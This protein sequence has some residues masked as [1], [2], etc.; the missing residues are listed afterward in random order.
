M[1][2]FR[3]DDD[4]LQAFASKLGRLGVELADLEAP[5]AEA[6]RI[7]L[8]AMRPPRLTG[9][10][11]ASTR[12]DVTAQGVTFAS[13]ARY[14]TFVHWGAPRRN[15]KARPFIT[16]AVDQAATD[17]AAVYAEHATETIRGL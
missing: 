16:E 14:W 13:T 6:G 9:Q 4:E 15:I 10:L 1:A 2:D 12:A 5:N 8:A 3:I 11:A 17:V 7:I